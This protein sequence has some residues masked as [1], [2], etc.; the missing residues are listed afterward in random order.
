[1]QDGR[2]AIGG[3]GG[4]LSRSGGPSKGR[5]TAWIV[6]AMA[7]ASLVASRPVEAQQAVEA[8][9]PELL[10]LGS[11]YQAAAPLLEIDFALSVTGV[12]ARGTVIQ[13]FRN[14]TERWLEGVYRFPLPETAA[15]D[16][17]RMKIGPRVIEGEI[18]EREEAR[19]TFERAR[20]AG[21]RASLVEQQRPDVF[22]SR[23]ANVGPGVEIAIEIDFQWTLDLGPGGF[24]LR[25]P[26]IVGPRFM[27]GDPGEGATG[28]TT[29]PTVGAPRPDVA[30]AIELDAGFPLA[31][32]ESPTHEIAL[33]QLGLHHFLVTLDRDVAPADRDFVLRWQPTP[34]ALPRA[35]LFHETRD[36]ED[37]LLMM[38]LPPD[39]AA[40]TPR[41]EREIVFVID[42]SGSMGGASIEHARRALTLALERLGPQDRFNVVAFASETR[43]LFAEPVFAV[44]E[45]IARA[46]RWVKALEADGG[47]EMLPALVEALR[48][49]RGGSGLRQVVFVT[50]GCVGNEQQL[51]AYVRENLGRSRLFT[52]GIGSAPNGHFMEGAARFGRGSRTFIASPGEVGERMA[53]L[54]AKLERPALTDVE[55]HWN[56]AVETWPAR[57]PDLYGGE[58]VLVTAKVE[59]FVGDVLVRGQLGDEAFE[60]RL[61]LAPGQPELGV[62]KLFGRRK[63]AALLDGLVLGEEEARV[64]EAVVA[65]ALEHGLVS[66]WTSLVAV[67]RA[68]VR[69]ASEALASGEVPAG[70]PAGF[71][72]PAGGT[73][74][75]LLRLMAVTSTLLSL[76][77]FFAVGRQRT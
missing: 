22:T 27:P 68:P 12:V 21:Q 58:P 41:R 54:F 25:L 32:L 20:E 53:A 6:F 19:Q 76:L 59:R 26:W 56:D 34:G 13:R 23:V 2:W 47:T 16:G 75:P 62:E 9:A 57:V 65:V 60:I 74:A 52:V 24:S 7:F 69:P 17:L 14:P 55:I 10:L 3:C 29:P 43:E 28:V 67:E 45:A 73:S 35:A 50:D 40:A 46:V 18:R 37:Y 31:S 72:L 64:R 61:P 11:D 15:V 8:P 39:A 48:D 38:L 70:M 71:L 42:T 5:P 30:F 4:G 33:E 1:M 51:F 77:L 66:R 63:I 36:G 44:P 49:D